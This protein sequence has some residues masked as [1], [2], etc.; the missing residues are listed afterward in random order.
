VLVL[1]V[2]DSFAGVMLALVLVRIANTLSYLALLRPLLR[3]MRA[4]MP[5]YK[6]R[7]QN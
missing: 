7:R 5:L 1:F 2:W 3:R 6:K 4:A